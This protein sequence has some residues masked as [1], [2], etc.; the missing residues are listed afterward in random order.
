LLYSSAENNELFFFSTVLNQTQQKPN[1]TTQPLTKK[2]H[3]MSKN[4]DYAKPK[5]DLGIL[6]HTYV[7]YHF[8]AITVLLTK[9]LLT[10]GLPKLTH[11]PLLRSFCPF[12][13]LLSCSKEFLNENRNCYKCD[14]VHHC[15]CNIQ[16]RYLPTQVEVNYIDGGTGYL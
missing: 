11:S 3:S 9:G 5:Y 10:E 2:M 13:G 8:Q 1:R 15:H 14:V 4:G 16:Y 6:N 12:L 7:R